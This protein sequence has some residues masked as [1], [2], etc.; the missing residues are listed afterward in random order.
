[1]IPNPE[2]LLVFIS[3]LNNLAQKVLLNF[4]QVQLCILHQ[5]TTTQCNYE[6]MIISD[7]QFLSFMGPFF[8]YTR[9]NGSKP[10]Q[11]NPKIISSDS[12]ELGGDPPILKV[13]GE[14]PHVPMEQRSNFCV[15]IV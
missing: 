8:P 3:T 14:N 1:M 2:H 5:P 12:N 9:H 7:K 4:H 10:A 13:Q 6:S 15:P 11:I